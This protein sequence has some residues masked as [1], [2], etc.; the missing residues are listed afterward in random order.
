MISVGGLFE[1]IKS[2]LISG[3]AYYKIIKGIITTVIIVL[4]AW[5]IA[6]LIGAICSYFMCYNKLIISSA[7]KGVCFFFRSTPVLLLLLLFYYVIFKRS[8]SLTML[9]AAMAIGLHGAG[10]FAELITKTVKENQ[11]WADK[12]LMQKLKAAYFTA[13]LPEAIEGSLFNIKRLMLCLLQWTTVVGYASVN[14]LTEVM[15][16]IGQRT[17]YPF[18]SIS[19]SIIF[20]L[21]AA[22]LI[23]WLFWIIK[24]K[25]VARRFKSE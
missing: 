14:D 25:L 8:H 5:L 23:E 1:A 12:R 7:A 10:L 18:F 6:F 3:Q 21:L 19:C 16:N 24:K 13:A 22:I 2:N 17:M 15:I 11:V 4:I 9:I 20:Y